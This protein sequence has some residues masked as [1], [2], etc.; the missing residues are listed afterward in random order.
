MYELQ[1]EKHGSDRVFVLNSEFA[2]LQM[3]YL[4]TELS[5]E[6]ALI[7]FCHAQMHQTIALGYVSAE[8]ISTKGCEMP[9]TLSVSHG[10][11]KVS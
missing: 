1:C 5:S 2:S 9:I 8:N 4:P 10:F 11:S 3:L 6:F 7:A